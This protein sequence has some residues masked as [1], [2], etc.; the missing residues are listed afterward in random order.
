MVQTVATAG[1][2]FCMSN[3]SVLGFLFFLNACQ[4]LLFSLFIFIFFHFLK[5]ATLMGMN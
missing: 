5:V 4:H 3:S 1:E 2:L